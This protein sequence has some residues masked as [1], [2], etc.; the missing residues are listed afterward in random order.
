MAM[1]IRIG[2]VLAMLVPQVAGAQVSQSTAASPALRDVSSDPDAAPP[3]P[4]PQNDADVTGGY[5]AAPDPE[6]SQ[7]TT[8]STATVPGIEDMLPDVGRA[9]HEGSGIV[10]SSKAAPPSPA[11]APQTNA[12]AIALPAGSGSLDSTTVQRIVDRL[13]GQHFLTSAADA[14]DPALFTEAIKAF[15]ASV[16]ISPTGMLDRDTIGRLVTQ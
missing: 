8:V 12:S 14:Q 16:G 9:S 4:V 3:P 10:H 11:P 6:P 15:Q 2:V 13:V 1:A 5:P 7:D